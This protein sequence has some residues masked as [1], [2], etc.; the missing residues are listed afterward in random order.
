MAVSSKDGS[1]RVG[2]AAEVVADPAVSSNP[3]AALSNLDPSKKYTLVFLMSVGTTLLVTGFSGGRLLKRAKTMTAEPVAVSSISTLTPSSAR[4]AANSSILSSAPSTSSSSLSPLRLRNPIASTSTLP[5]TSSL[6]SRRA[7]PAL[8]NLAA[9]FPSAEPQHR[10]LLQQWS[11]EKGSD[12]SYWLSNTSLASDSAAAVA[13]SEAYDK[14]GVGYEDKTEGE[15]E[16][17][18]DDGFNPAV[19]AAK[20][21]AIA[22]VLTVGTFGIAIAAVMKWY[23][24]SD[25]RC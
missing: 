4:P 11:K 23:E 24:V 12:L 18:V 1:D 6:S 19:F 3:L 20:A 21:F 17:Y 9:S 7:S 13:A 25:V 5:H 16:P 14:Q 10:S 22:S 15:E 8:M 2:V